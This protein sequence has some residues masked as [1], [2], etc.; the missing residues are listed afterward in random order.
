MESG[1]H[2]TFQYKTCIKSY[3]IRFV[4]S[5][6]LKRVNMEFLGLIIYIIV[7]IIKLLLFLLINILSIFVRMK[8]ID[9]RF[10]NVSISKY[11]TLWLRGYMSHNLPSKHSNSSLKH[12]Y[13]ILFLHCLTHR[14]KLTNASN[15]LALFSLS[16]TMPQAFSYTDT[17]LS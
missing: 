6:Q 10:Y 11:V 8:T 13:Y 17:M 15:L 16:L 14:G 1:I 9:H 4:E 7:A 3:P 2:L 12:K 5:L